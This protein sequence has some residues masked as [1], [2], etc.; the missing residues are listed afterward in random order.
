V[1]SPIKKKNTNSATSSRGKCGP[2][3]SH[4]EGSRE[5][6][7][8]AHLDATT[9][10]WRLGHEQESV[11]DVVLQEVSSLSLAALAC[12]APHLEVK[13]TKYSGT[14]KNKL[15]LFINTTHTIISGTVYAI[16]STG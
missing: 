10:S 4:S 2:V 16:L 11:L 13:I 6:A 1:T 12:G 5:D 7:V 3:R 15:G 14:S 9:Q 8:N